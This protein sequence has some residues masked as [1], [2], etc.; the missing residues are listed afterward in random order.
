MI[1][2]ATSR[3]KCLLCGN[4]FFNQK[5]LNIHFGKAHKAVRKD[6]TPQKRKISSVKTSWS[7]T[8]MTNPSQKRSLTI[9]KQKNSLRRYFLF[10][11]YFRSL[12]SLYFIYFTTGRRDAKR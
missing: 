3:V 4:I 1:G 8:Y 12:N 11:A 2:S 5:G 10:D 6:E 7:K 9:T